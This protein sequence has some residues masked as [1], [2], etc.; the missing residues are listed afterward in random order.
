MQFSVIIIALSLL[1]I[2]CARIIGVAVPAEIAPGANFAIT[3]ITQNYIQSVVD[4][5]AAFGLTQTIY[6]DSLGSYLAS[7]YFGPEESNV[8]YNISVN[9]NMLPSVAP[10]SA[11]YLTAAITSLYGAASE[12]TTTLYSVPITIG[13]STNSDLASDTNGMN[14][15]PASSPSSTAG[16]T[17]TA[18]A[19]SIVTTRTDLDTIISYV[20]TGL[21]SLINDIIRVDMA[22]AQAEYDSLESSFD[23][24]LAQ[25]MLPRGSCSNT[26]GDASLGDAQAI[27]TIQTMQDL[28]SQVSV[29]A[30]NGNDILAFEDA[31]TAH[32]DYDELHAFIFG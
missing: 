30:T 29:E 14:S 4:I 1:S 22:S 17:A 31:C 21:T 6:P 5:S 3:V 7:T 19:S 11:Y 15:C 24:I 8:V 25:T 10:G 20:Q 2:A 16:A 9:A 23:E 12:V 26:T 28:L 18:S 32:Q 13:Y 27:E